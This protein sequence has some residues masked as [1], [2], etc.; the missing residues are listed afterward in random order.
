[1][2]RLLLEVSVSTGGASAAWGG[3]C[4]MRRADLLDSAPDG[5]MQH[6]KD[7]GYS[8]DWII[9]QVARR[10]NR[11]IS[12][13]PLLFLNLV[14][15][16][17]LKQVYNFL[18][19]QFFVLDT[20]VRPPLGESSLPWVDPHRRE[21]YL[22]GLLQAT[23][24]LIFSL[25]VPLLFAQLCLLCLRLARP[26]AGESAAAGFGTPDQLALCVCVAAPFCLLAVT[27][28]V[29]MQKRIVCT[30]SPDVG[31]TLASAARSSLLL[32]PLGFVIYT[33]MAPFFVGQAV[34]CSSVVWSGARYFKRDGRVARVERPSSTAA[35]EAP[36]PL[37]PA[38]IPRSTSAGRLSDSPTSR[39]PPL[40]CGES[41]DDSSERSDNSVR[42]IRGRA[43]A[44]P[45]RDRLSVG[46][47][48]SIH[49]R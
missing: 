7:D 10:H 15:F 21:S 4:M 48:V 32:A 9:T 40:V 45:A 6:W 43:A 18:H 11:R 1:M 26:S 36:G 29:R 46:R 31:A 19:R 25:G 49:C 23:L 33:A 30:L 24:G 37:L 34:L 8:D 3:C 5:V 27:L 16:S 28:L 41:S 12:N 42:S 17:T 35:E 2:F 20:Y 44:K 13:P 22:L 38:V 39:Q 47:D 14:E